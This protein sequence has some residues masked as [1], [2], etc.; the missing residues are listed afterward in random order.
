MPQVC[1]EGV[2]CLQ[3]SSENNRALIVYIM[4]KQTTAPSIRALGVM[5][6]ILRYCRDQLCSKGL[7]IHT[8][9]ETRRLPSGCRDLPVP[10]IEWLR[11]SSFGR[12]WQQWWAIAAILNAEYDLS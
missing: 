5:F 7:P 8:C 12:V 3:C 1:C 9:A 11:I 4:F 10:Q 6:N 2:I